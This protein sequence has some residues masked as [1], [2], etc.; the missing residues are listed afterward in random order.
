METK[1]NKYQ[2]LTLC[3]IIVAAAFLRLMHL[4]YNFSPIGAMAIFSGAYFGKKWQSFIIPLVA[5]FISDIALNYSFYHKLVLFNEM[6]IW[7]YGAFAI[8]VFVGIVMIKKVNATSVFKA[9]LITSV[10]FFIITNFGVWALAGVTNMYPHNFSGLVSCYVA[11]I[12][13]FLRTLAGDLFFS[14][15]IFGVFEIAKKYLFNYKIA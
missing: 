11:A 15:I 10:L 4:P 6:F 8:N 12:P 5:L 1:N 13:F 9:S 7:V 2:L 14:A 3:V